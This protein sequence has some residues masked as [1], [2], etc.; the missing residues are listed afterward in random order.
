MRCINEFVG[1]T[2]LFSQIDRHVYQELRKLLILIRNIYLNGRIY[3]VNNSFDPILL[4]IN[5]S[6]EV[7]W[8]IH[9]NV[10]RK[11]K[12]SSVYSLTS[13]A[14]TSI[15]FPQLEISL[16]RIYK[17]VASDSAATSTSAFSEYEL[18]INAFLHPYSTFDS[19]KIIL[20][21]IIARIDVSVHAYVYGDVTVESNFECNLKIKRISSKVFDMMTMMSMRVW[22]K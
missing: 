11:N 10:D 13:T 17:V 21:V 1:G 18:I 20:N 8:R 22:R 5:Y 9:L 14:H 7:V 3:L 19:I 15:P 12:H 16:I 6:C 4:M 2:K